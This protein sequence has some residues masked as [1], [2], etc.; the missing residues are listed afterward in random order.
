M[1]PFLNKSFKSIANYFGF[2]EHDFVLSGFIL[3]TFQIKTFYVK[4]KFSLE[5]EAIMRNVF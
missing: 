3:S 4:K 5:K 1:P 2:T